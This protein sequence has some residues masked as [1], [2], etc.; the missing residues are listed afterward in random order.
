MTHALD[1][2][3]KIHRG[4]GSP[5]QP[6][7]RLGILGDIHVEDERLKT[8]IAWQRGRGAE[9][10]VHVGDVVDGRGSLERTLSLLSAHGVVGVSGNHERWFLGG[11]MR[12]LSGAHPMDALTSDVERSLRMVPPLLE[13]AT[14]RGPL[15]L[16]HGVGRDDM[17]VLRPDTLLGFL[18]GEPAFEEL[19]AARRFSFVA[20]GHTHQRAV[21]RVAHLT[22]INA[23]TL[24][25][26]DEPVATLVDFDAGQVHF[27]ALDEPSR[28]GAIETVPLP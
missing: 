10:I 13:L 5:G 20:C 11:A 24:K 8:A 2:V 28:V 17:T 19:I 23:G 6:L 12:Q 22:W 16:C 25:W 15:L 9:R 21:H 27:G 3:P 14:V 1:D 18:F 4:P 7:R 26:D